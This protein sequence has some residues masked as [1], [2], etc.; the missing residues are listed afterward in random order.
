MYTK[1]FTFL[2]LS[3]LLSIDVGGQEEVTNAFH[4]LQRTGIVQED[5]SIMRKVASDQQVEALV[6]KRLDAGSFCFAEDR[7]HEF[8]RSK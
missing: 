2:I 7:E 6:Q 1:K 4:D 8:G 3:A 5:Q